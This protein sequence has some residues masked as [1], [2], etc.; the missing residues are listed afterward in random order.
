MLAKLGLRNRKKYL[1]KAL[2]E[3]G[4]TLSDWTGLLLSSLYIS[5][6]GRI[7]VKSPLTCDPVSRIAILKGRPGQAWPLIKRMIVNL[8][9]CLFEPIQPI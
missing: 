2:L 3:T 1:Y 9:V 5:P 4:V 6:R 7:I 8:N